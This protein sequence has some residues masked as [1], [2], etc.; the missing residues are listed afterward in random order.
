MYKTARYPP[1]MKLRHVG[2]H[3]KELEP[4][5]REQLRLIKQK[6]N[7]SKSVARQLE[8]SLK[9]DIFLSQKQAI[10][11]DGSYHQKILVKDTPVL[12]AYSFDVLGETEQENDESR[13]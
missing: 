8:M 13:D 1:S 2:K 10:H 11:G 6:I 4:N 9:G 5:I 12:H 7:E 3:G